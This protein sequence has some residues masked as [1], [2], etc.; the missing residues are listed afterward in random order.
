MTKHDRSISSIGMTMTSSTSPSAP[1]ATG[2]A[3]A[4]STACEWEKFVDETSQTP[5]YY[6][7]RTGE[8][9]WSEPEGFVDKSSAPKLPSVWRKF[10]DESA[11]TA[12]YYDEANDVTQWEKPDGFVDDASG[13]YCVCLLVCDELA[14][15]DVIHVHVSLSLLLA[16]AEDDSASEDGDASDGDNEAAKDADDTTKETAGDGGKA[17]TSQEQAAAASEQTEVDTSEGYTSSEKPLE[18]TASATAD[19]PQAPSEAPA[20]ASEAQAAPATAAAAQQQ[21]ASNW[22]KHVDQA[23]GRAYYHNTVSGVTQWDAP[24]DF[25]EA[26]PMAAAAV[27]YHAHLHRVQAERMARVTRQVLDPTGSLARLNAVLSTVNAS[28]AGSSR[29]D[30]TGAPKAEWQQHVDPQTQ[31]FYYHNVVTGVTQWH[32]P[33]ASISSGVRTLVDPTGLLASLVA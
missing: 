19:E 28:S 26:P 22:V 3:A 9:S 25:V 13:A 4:A 1:S 20:V 14:L 23:S 8:S 5:Y 27:E 17:H 6:N 2:A 11:G 15:I 16:D 33:D 31:R 12:Y 10:I 21:T 30:A 29:G 18:A 32:K 24:A 7:A